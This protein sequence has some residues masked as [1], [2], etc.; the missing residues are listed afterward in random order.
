MSKKEIIDQFKWFYKKG[1]ITARDGNAAYRIDPCGQYMVTAS[2]VEKYNLKNGDFLVVGPKGETYGDG[3]PSIE[4]GAHLAVLEGSG[5]NASIHVHSPNTVALAALFE[6]EAMWKPNSRHL[7]GVL[8]TKWPE[9]FRHTKVGEVVPFLDPGTKWLHESIT[10]A[11]YRHLSGKWCDI[12]IMQRHGVLATGD[13]LQECMEHIV[14]LEH[15][16]GILLKIITASGNT[17]S[18]L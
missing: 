10:N 12:V 15:L 9:L 17:T 1:Y 8:N 4:T 3:K 16:S 18:I 6:S 5:R 14:R 13:S 7:V 11:M 2:G